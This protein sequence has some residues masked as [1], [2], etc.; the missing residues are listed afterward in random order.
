MQGKTTIEATALVFGFRVTATAFRGELWTGLLLAFCIGTSSLMMGA[1]IHT[2]LMA[3]EEGEMP[4][5]REIRH[6][7]S[8]GNPC[9][10][11]RAGSLNGCLPEAFVSSCR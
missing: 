3:R 4:G 10:V 7:G 11:N 2:V 9:L 5:K 8:Q 6:D 1:A